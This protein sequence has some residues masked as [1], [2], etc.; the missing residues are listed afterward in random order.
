LKQ[1]G[2]YYAPE[3]N[4]IKILEILNFADDIVLLSHNFKDMQI[5]PKSALAKKQD[6]KRLRRRRNQRWPTQMR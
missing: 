6:K 3:K 1:E 2:T 5:P 4:I